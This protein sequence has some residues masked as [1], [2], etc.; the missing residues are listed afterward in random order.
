MRAILGALLGVIV[1]LWL[2]TLRLR[3]IDRVSEADRAAD[4][5]WVLVFWHGT[6]I[7][8]LAWRRRRKTA[9]L[10]SWSKDGEL[11]TGVMRRAGMHVVRGSSSRGGARGLIEMV[12]ALREHRLDGAFAVDG[13]RGPRGEVHPGALACARHAKGVLVPIGSAS[14]PARVL[15]RAWDKMAVPLP[16]SRAIVVLGPALPATATDEEL[17]AAIDEANVAA[18]RALDRVRHEPALPGRV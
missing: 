17:S 5:P 10:V 12:R 18:A 7:P 13:P 2:R 15:E 1:W 8:L 16:F 11:Q 4:A 14:S 6:Q 3:V 9:V